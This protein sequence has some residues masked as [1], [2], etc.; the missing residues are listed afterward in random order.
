MGNP[1]D[2]P[3]GDLS[4]YPDR[5]TYSLILAL[6]GEVEDLSPQVYSVGSV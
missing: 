6:S 2:F 3:T 4:R 1:A 5:E